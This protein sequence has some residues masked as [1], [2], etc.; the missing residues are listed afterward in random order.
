MG[1]ASDVDDSVAS[2]GAGAFSIREY[3]DTKHS[4]F[5]MRNCFVEGLLFQR[6]HV[7]TNL[8]GR[9]PE[10]GSESDGEGFDVPA[11]YARLSEVPDAHEVQ[12]RDGSRM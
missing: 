11:G 6:V 5:W 10:N 4:L 12:W 7:D 2:S 3:R 1:I 9:C 8:D